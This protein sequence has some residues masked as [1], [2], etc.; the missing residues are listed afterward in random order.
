MMIRVLVRPPLGATF[1]SSCSISARTSR[2]LKSHG[3]SPN[4]DSISSNFETAACAWCCSAKR[5]RW[6]VW[7]RGQTGSILPVMVMCAAALIRSTTVTDAAP[8]LSPLVAKIRLLYFRPFERRGSSVRGIVMSQNASTEP[9]HAVKAL[10]T[11]AYRGD[12]K[13]VLAELGDGADINARDCD[14]DT[15]LILAAE[16]GHVELVQELLKA[17]AEV[18][19]RNLIG[20]TALMRAAENGL[21]EVV[22]LLL[23][24]HAECNAG[25]NINCTSLMRAAY[26]GHVDVVK[27]LLAAGADV[28]ARNAFGNTAAMLAARNGHSEVESLLPRDHDLNLVN[29]IQPKLRA[30]RR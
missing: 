21:A 12:V 18:D 5:M 22:K 13:T 6:P 25:N 24:R 10:I 29:S 3:S 28:H 19:A 11:A 23:A 30:Q 17:G 15:A 7:F 27:E 2:S 26:R 16:R 4:H 14:G 8:S 20:E 1:R 9:N